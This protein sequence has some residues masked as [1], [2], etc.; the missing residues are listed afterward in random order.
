M[1]FLF[2]DFQELEIFSVTP[3]TNSTKAEQFH[4]GAFLYFRFL[5]KNK[6]LYQKTIKEQKKKVIN[7]SY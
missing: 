6:I 2:K 5:G 7:I 1:A 4:L 3:C